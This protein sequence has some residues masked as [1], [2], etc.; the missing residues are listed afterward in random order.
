MVL[1][2]LCCIGLNEEKRDMNTSKNYNEILA[3]AL[4]RFNRKTNAD[5][6]RALND[7]ELAKMLSR[8][9]KYFCCDPDKCD[10]RS[11][12]C[13]YGDECEECWLDWLRQ[14]AKE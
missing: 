14:E 7:E 2:Q 1:L 4:D 8:S 12:R 6:L 11:E 9:G 3:Q 5:K 13:D 10:P